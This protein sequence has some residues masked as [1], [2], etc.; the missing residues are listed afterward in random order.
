MPTHPESDRHLLLGGGEWN[1][2]TLLEAGDSIERGLIFDLRP[3]IAGQ[4]LGQACDALLVGKHAARRPHLLSASRHARHAD[5]VVM[6]ED[7]FDGLVEHRDGQAVKMR[8]G[9]DD[10]VA[11]CEGLLFR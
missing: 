3:V 11:T 6:G 2:E 4:C 7:I 8:S 1:A 5:R 9:D 10:H